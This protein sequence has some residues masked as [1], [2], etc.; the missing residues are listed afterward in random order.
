MSSALDGLRVIDLSRVLGGPYCAQLLGDH[1]ADVIKIEPPAGDETRGWGP[2]FINGSAA[3]YQGLNRS[4]RG[5]ALD[6]RH[7]EGREVLLKLLADAD[8]LVENF[9]AGT[10]EKWGIGYERLHRLFPRLIHCR[11]S[12]FGADGPLGGLPGYDAVA[13]AMGGLMSVNGEKGGDPLRV[14]LPLVDMVTGLNAVAGITLALHERTR[15]GE[16]QFVEAALFDSALA[17]MHPHFP[18]VFAGGAEPQRM[19]NAHP[20]IAPYDA[21]ATATQNI[22]LAVGNNAQFAK[23]CTVLESPEI[24]EDPRFQ[25]NGSRL[26][27]SAELRIALETALSRHGGSEIA[28]RLIRA[29]VPCGPVLGANEV[30]RHPHTAHRGMLVEIGAY[31]GT[32]TPVKLGRTPASYRRVPPAFAEHS[33]EIL[34]ELGLNENQIRALRESGVAPD[35]L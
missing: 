33:T 25:D 14:G 10:L 8:V 32:G 17:L 30:L 35:S 20:N 22:F 3:Y 15:S 12:G 16:G 34:A 21:Y 9:K 6:L 5:L 7:E 11:I 24:L 23:L 29:G 26:A 28:E 1:G 13:Q 19:G 2:P 27:H 31:K 18:N 4:K